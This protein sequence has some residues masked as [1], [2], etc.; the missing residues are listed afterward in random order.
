MDTAFFSGERLLPE[1][2]IMTA[3][4]KS[5]VIRKKPTTWKE[6]KLN[7][8]GSTG[9]ST[10][11]GVSSGVIGPIRDFGTVVRPLDDVNPLEWCWFADLKPVLTGFTKIREPK[12][13]H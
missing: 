7:C 13:P 12:P 1:F 11:T 5:F 8:W 10:S 3:S 9:G 6:L 2:E 4:S